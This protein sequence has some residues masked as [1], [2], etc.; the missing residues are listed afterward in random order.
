MLQNYLRQHDRVLDSIRFDYQGG[1][2]NGRGVMTW[3]PDR[4]FHIEAPVQRVGPLPHRIGFGAGGIIRE[5]DVHSIRMRERNASGWILAPEVIMRDLLNLILQERLSI[6]VPRII[7][8]THVGTR[9]VDSNTWQGRV[10]LKLGHNPILPDR[11]IRQERINEQELGYSWQ[12]SAIHFESE[13]GQRVLGRIVEQEYLELSYTLPRESWSHTEAW[14][15]GEA[16]SYALSICMGQTI[17]VLQRELSWANKLYEDTRRQIQIQDIRPFAPLGDEPRV[18]RSRFIELSNFLARQGV[19]AEVCRRIFLQMAEAARQETW[20]GTA[21]L[22]TTV[23]E[24][25]LRTLEGHPFQLDDRSFNLRIA[26]RNFRE[27][28]FS[29]EW[30]D[31]FERAYQTFRRLRHRNA[32]PDWL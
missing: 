2:Y 31:L 3:D 30:V 12:F 24:A 1:R 13:G 32:H 17:T 18:E 28:Y 11:V 9:A 16:A 20:Q 21:L 26:F 8:S 4:G 10:L 19:G 14:R 15:W 6:H 22:L 27:R 29:E 23:L 5:N 7:I 25:A